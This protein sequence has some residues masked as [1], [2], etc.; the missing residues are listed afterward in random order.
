MWPDP[1]EW[2]SLSSQREVSDRVEH[3]QR[4]IGGSNHRRRAGHPLGKPRHR[5]DVDRPRL[6]RG[7]R[8]AVGGCG[9]DRSE[10]QTTSRDCP[11]SSMAAV[12]H[13][14]S[15]LGDKGL[16]RAGVGLLFSTRLTTA[17][18]AVQA[19]M[20]RL[21]SKEWSV[22][23][24]CHRASESWLAANP[25]EEAAEGWELAPPLANRLVH[26]DWPVRR[27]KAVATGWRSASLYLRCFSPRRRR[28]PIRSLRGAAVAA[29]LQVRTEP[30]AAGPKG[31]G[32]LQ[33]GLAEPA[34]LG[35]SCGSRRRL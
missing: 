1:R 24:H 10:S 3:R 29:F 26:L 13:G 35:G 33:P 20:L 19:A 16:Q 23:L 34:E 17:P 6:S 15:G 8:L 30:R 31:G 2:R 7:S 32:A 11:S 28:S 18:P 22:N 25:P 27:G 4:S 21:Y 9:S 14:S 5:K 12:A